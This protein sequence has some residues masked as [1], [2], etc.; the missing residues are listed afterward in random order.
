MVG[1]HKWLVQFGSGMVSWGR[2]VGDEVI[3]VKKWWSGMGLR[4]VSGVI[5]P[6][7]GYWVLKVYPGGSLGVG[8]F[9]KVIELFTGYT[10]LR[11]I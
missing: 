7:G 11:H 4:V 2:R 5:G 1:N 6:Q 3:G 8:T 9:T 10:H